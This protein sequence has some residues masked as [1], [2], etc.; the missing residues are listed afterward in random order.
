[1]DHDPT[2]YYDSRWTAEDAKAAPPNPERVARVTQAVLLREKFSTVSV[3]SFDLV[4]W[5]HLHPRAA[6][7]VRRMQAVR[8]GWRTS[9]LWE[10][11]MLAVARR[12]LYLLAKATGP[13]L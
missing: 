7:F 9:R 11:Y 12:G 6:E 2:S 10:R 13:R 5:S 4:F 3:T 8:G 1:M